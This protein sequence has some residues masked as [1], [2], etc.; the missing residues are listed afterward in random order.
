[1]E[2]ITL[3]N[4]CL[5]SAE[6]KVMDAA[7]YYVSKGYSV[8]V[9][10]L[11]SHSSGTK[12]PE[13]KG[14]S[15][16]ALEY[17]LEHDDKALFKILSNAKCLFLDKQYKPMHYSNYMS[18]IRVAMSSRVPIVHVHSL[19]NLKETYDF[20]DSIEFYVMSEIGGES[21]R[22]DHRI[23]SP[24]Y[25]LH[26]MVRDSKNIFEAY[27][28]IL[29]IVAVREYSGLHIDYTSGGENKEQENNLYSY[30]KSKYLNQIDDRYVYHNSKLEGYAGCKP[31]NSI[32]GIL[33]L[34]VN[35][36][37]MNTGA[38]LLFNS[39]LESHVTIYE[40]IAEIPL[41]DIIEASISDHLNRKYSTYEKTTYMGKI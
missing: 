2:V 5:N 25:G 6:G 32:K 16:I 40:Q 21:M 3:V 19:G 29:R 18:L 33:S 30:S 1:M 34:V 22:N 10:G 7:E 17:H 38:D 24:E 35:N 26:R 31:D 14:V 28:K 13:L 15:F 37:D 4:G 12:L 20:D 36:E 27:R 23:V 8:V 39:V 11:E 9:I 41:S